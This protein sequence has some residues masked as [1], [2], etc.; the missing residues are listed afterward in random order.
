MSSRASC[1][2]AVA[3]WVLSACGGG[4]D[5]SP[6]PNSPNPPT[7]ATTITVSGR[8]VNNWK[9]PVAGMPVVVSGKPPLVTDGNGRFSVSDVTT[10]YDV[11]LVHIASRTATIYKGLTRADPVLVGSSDAPASQTAN[12]SGSVSGISLPQ[13]ALHYTAVYVITDGGYEYNFASTAGAWAFPSFRWYGS[14]NT[15]GVMHA[16]QVRNSAGGVPVEYKAYG[17]REGVALASGGTFAAQNVRLNAIPNGNVSGTVSVA[18]GYTLS[19][20]GLSLQLSPEY[21]MSL[22][23]ENTSAAA[24]SFVTPNIGPTALM[25]YASATKGGAGSTVYRRGLPATASGIA[26]SIPAGPGQ[27]LPADGTTGVGT[28]TQFSWS[29]FAGGVHAAEFYSDA[30]N[31]PTYIIY[32]AGTSTTIPDLSSVGLGLPPA[33]PYKWSVLALAPISNIDQIAVDAGFWGL[34]RTLPG[35]S[36]LVASAERVFNTSP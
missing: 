19:T 27:N 3:V 35:D 1:I 11:S 4:S 18:A 28:T 29:A 16:L 9:N 31:K 12:V 20:K 25:L 34:F 32:T 23:S 6:N 26:L 10:P 7:T 8:V 2:A 36:S 5:H 33:T 14:P 24:F 21:D 17:K 15:T 30:A 22:Q 13:P